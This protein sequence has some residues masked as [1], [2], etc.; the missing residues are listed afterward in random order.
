MAL[1]WR[2]AMILMSRLQTVVCVCDPT[3]ATMGGGLLNK[4]KAKIHENRE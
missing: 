4:L 1:H 2:Q 3:S